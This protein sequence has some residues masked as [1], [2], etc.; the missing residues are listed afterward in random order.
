MEQGGDAILSFLDI[1]FM[2]TLIKHINRK[3]INWGLNIYMS[4]HTAIEVFPPFLIELISIVSVTK[5]IYD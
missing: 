3:G 1:N 5:L 2:L 4:S